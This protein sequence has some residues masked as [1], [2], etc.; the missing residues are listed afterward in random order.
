MS[1]SAQL[2]RCSSYRPS[3]GLTYHL[4]SPGWERVSMRATWLA[5]GSVVETRDI[6]SG[7]SPTA[8]LESD[9]GREKSMGVLL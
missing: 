7:P 1:R 9:E 3:C 6:R 2:A 5:A 4:R 8:V